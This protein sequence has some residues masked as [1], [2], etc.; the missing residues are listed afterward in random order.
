VSAAAPVARSPARGLLLPAILTVLAT[1][2]LIGLGTW[3]MQRLH[4]KEGL[5]AEIAERT[6]APPLTI[7][8]SSDIARLSSGPDEYR[9]VAVTGTFRNEDSVQVYALLGEPR[10]RFGGAGAWVITPLVLDD[11]GIVLVNRGF[12]PAERRDPATW[13]DPVPQGRLVVTGLLRAPE[14]PNLFT[15]ADDPPKRSFF[16]RDPAPIAAALGLREV[17]PF[18]VDA[19][20]SGA[21]GALPQGGETRLTFDNRHLEYALTWYGLAAALLGVFCAFAISRLRRNM[22]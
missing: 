3:Q 1:A 16:S 17:A 5:L 13:S 18:T 4:W 8:S 14:Q 15:P 19:D 11:G 21:A 10:G 12:V 6:Q 22:V 9:R 2:V 7:A 20:A